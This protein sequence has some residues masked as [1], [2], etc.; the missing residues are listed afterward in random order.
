VVLPQAARAVY[1]AIVNNLIQLLL[2]TSLLSAITLPELMGTA[3]VINS[4]TLLYIQT[5]SI[6]L[7]AYLVL[8]NV[9]S[10]LAAQLGARIFHPPIVIKKRA[11]LPF[12]TARQAGR[13]K[14]RNGRFTMSTDLLMTNLSILLQGLLTTLLLSVGA[15]VGGT[16]IGL[17]AAILRSFGPWGT[18]A[19]AKLYTEL[20]D[21]ERAPCCAS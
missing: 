16:L 8:S 18:P 9:F 17:F 7:I 10:W 14:A 11:R 2:G 3:T 4:R 12:L 6:A 21:R 13:T 19:V 20:R 5:F 1:P 15:I